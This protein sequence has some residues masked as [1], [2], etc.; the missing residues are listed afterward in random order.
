MIIDEIDYVLIDMQTNIEVYDSV[1]KD[2]KY[3][4]SKKTPTIIGLTA[5]KFEELNP[6]EKMFLTGSHHTFNF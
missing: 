1:K 5:T 6:D 4:K 2:G 3:K